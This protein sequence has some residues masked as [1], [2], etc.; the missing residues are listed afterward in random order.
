MGFAISGFGYYLLHNTMQVQG[1][2][3]A[4]QARGA[5]VALLASGFFIGQGLGPIF[6]GYLGIILVGPLLGV[7]MDRFTR[8]S[9]AAAIGA[10]KET[11]SL[12]TAIMEGIDGVKVVKIDNREAYEEARVAAAVER[13]QNHI[14]RGAN[15]RLL[16]ESRIIFEGKMSSL[17]RFK[18]D[19]KEVAT[20]F[21]CGIGIEN[22]NDLK[23]G[24][25]IEAYQI[26]LITPTLDA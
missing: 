21:E 3:L 6:T 16:R 1:T 7:V 20:G 5:A 13:R 11:S 10:M 26:E 17:R 8:W 12:S 24:D 19:A 18:D 23:A 9:R 14:I 4:P 2:E 15:V 25:I 22:Y